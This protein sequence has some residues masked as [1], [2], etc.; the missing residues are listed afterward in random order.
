MNQK[1]VAVYLF[2]SV[3]LIG[4]VALPGWA[5]GGGQPGERGPDI[6][7]QHLGGGPGGEGPG[8]APRWDAPADRPREQAG[9]ARRFGGGYGRGGGWVPRAQGDQPPFGRGRDQ[10]P[11]NRES[12][13]PFEPGFRGGEKTEAGVTK[14]PYCENCPYCQRAREGR[15]GGQPAVEGGRRR[16]MGMMRHMREWDPEVAQKWMD[17]LKAGVPPRP[18]FRRALEEAGPGSPFENERPAFER[19]RRFLR[20][21]PGFESRRPEARELFERESAEQER[22][23][24]QPGKPEREESREI[25]KHVP[26]R[27]EAPAHSGDLDGQIESLNHRLNALEE[28]LEDLMEKLPKWDSAP[29]EEREDEDKGSE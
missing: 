7:P 8:E 5:Q 25:R 4:A 15:G 3:L 17:E 20:E 11:V 22:G 2:A 27:E 9:P 18:A 21:R 26:E 1:R 29:R 14:C 28:K 16:P 23:D 13:P 10:G 12:Q 24:R 19:F 6:A